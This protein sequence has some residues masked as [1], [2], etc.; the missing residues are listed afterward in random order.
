MS[1]EKI[2]SITG[3]TTTKTLPASGTN[4]RFETS[5]LTSSGTLAG[6]QVQAMASY[7]S[8]LREDGTVYG[9]C[10]NAGVIMTQDGLATFRATGIG[11]FTED[12]G[13]MF[14]GVAYFQTKAPSLSSL[15]G[16]AVV[17]NWDVD[18][19]GNAQWELWEWR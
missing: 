11:H 6:A 13:A 9:E 12:G 10:P 5:L 17:Y 4:P 3:T 8:E 7:S 19:E 1:A 15:N 2:G 16:S 18:A 14:K